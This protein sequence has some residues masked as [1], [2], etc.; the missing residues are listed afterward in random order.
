MPAGGNTVVLLLF[1]NRWNRNISATNKKI[2]VKDHLT[3]HTSS[4]PPN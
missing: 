4:K 3:F 1:P 2:K